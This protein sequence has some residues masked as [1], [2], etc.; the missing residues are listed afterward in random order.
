MTVTKTFFLTG[1]TGLVG[2]YLLK[3]LLTHGHTVYALSRGNKNST[4]AERILEKLRFW[5]EKLNFDS[6]KI[7][8]GDVAKDGLG[9]TKEDFDLLCGNVDEIFH[10][11]AITD[12]NRQTQEIE[13]VNVKGTKRVLDAA[14][15]W[16]KQGRLQKINHISTAY[17]YGNYEGEFTEDDLDVGQSFDSNYIETK[18]K[19][20]KLV[21]EYRA[22]GLWIDIYRSSIVI[23][24]SKTG[25]TFQFKHLY[26]FFEICR[27]EIFDV[28]PV[29]GTRISVVT[30]DALSE[31]IYLISQSTRQKNRRYHPF[32]DQLIPTAD[33]IEIGSRLSGF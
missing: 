1:G 18:Y 6:L 15:V 14:L 10:C 16:Q 11:A 19:A 5:D 13:N 29:L 23:G 3:I 32:P 17:V 12:L 2:S 26:Q 20:E 24:D 33:I 4:A 8:E 21:E 27:L 7:V 22:K 25:K 9:L 30:V 31:A 28:L